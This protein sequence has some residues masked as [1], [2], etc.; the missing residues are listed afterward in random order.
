MHFKSCHC[1]NFWLNFSLPG[2]THNFQEM[3][4]AAL[5][6]WG[7]HKRSYKINFKIGIPFLFSC[8]LGFQNSIWLNGE[9]KKKEKRGKKGKKGK[10]KRMSIAL[11]FL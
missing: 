2:I 7:F 6:S 1:I 5:I 8:S 10:K 4:N 11:I 9:K 3:S